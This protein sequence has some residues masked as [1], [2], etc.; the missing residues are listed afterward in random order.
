M[1]FSLKL[2]LF[3]L[4]LFLLASCGASVDTEALVGKWQGVNLDYKQQGG[5]VDASSS[6]YDFKTDGTYTGTDISGTPESGTYK[7]LLNTLYLTPTGGSK[8]ALEL[9][10]QT[11]EKLVFNINPGAIPLL[12][13]LK[14]VR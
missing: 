5:L 3:L 6:Y 10:S 14:R 8:R 12:L 2:V 11:A 4:P 9:E 7:S 13:T 1:Q